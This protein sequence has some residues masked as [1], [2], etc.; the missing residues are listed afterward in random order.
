[1]AYNISE[2]LLLILT[3]YLLNFKK[4]SNNSFENSVD[5]DLLASFQIF[6]RMLKC[7]ARGNA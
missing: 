7:L 3:E 2:V 1:M 4:K 5:Q 6:F